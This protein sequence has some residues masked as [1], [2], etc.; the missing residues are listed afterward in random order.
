MDE[1][2]KLH[3]ALIQQNSDR[4]KSIADRRERDDLKQYQSAKIIG[5]SRTSGQWLIALNGATIQ[6]KSLTNSAV[7]VGQSVTYYRSDSEAYGYF[8][9]VP[10]G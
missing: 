2:T 6:A 9:A 5:Y 1:L 4:I 8:D 10:I 3:Q 7:N